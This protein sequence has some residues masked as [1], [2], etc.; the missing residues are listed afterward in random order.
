[1]KTYRRALEGGSRK[2]GCLCLSA[3]ISGAVLVSGSAW[4]LNEALPKGP[5]ILSGATHDIY[6]RGE[7][8]PDDGMA[9]LRGGFSL[10]G[11]ELSFGAKLTTLINNA[12]RYE[13]EIAF[14]RAGAEIISRTL[15]QGAGAG[16]VTL[17]GPDQA[18]GAGDIMGGLNLRGLA[19]FSGVLVSDGNGG[20][21][22]ALHQITR[23]AIINTLSTTA[24]GQSVDNHIDVSIHVRN[25]GEIRAARQKTMILNSLQGIPR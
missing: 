18:I 10:A 24:S 1:M 4:A 25:I 13:T 9:D 11:M 19:D 8:L 5:G 3:L 6:Y 17:V 22:A 21:V 23:N 7:V 15:T 20:M 2:I 12:I 16:N 14:T